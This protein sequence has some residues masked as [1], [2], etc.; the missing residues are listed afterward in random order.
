MAETARENGY[1]GEHRA[2]SHRRLAPPLIHCTPGFRTESVPMFLS[3]NAT[4]PP[5]E[6]R[7]SRFTRK[8]EDEADADAM[9]ADLLAVSPKPEPVTS[10]PAPLPAFHHGRCGL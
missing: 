7:A 9:R 10:S 2:R 8:H 3:D 4:G 5:G 1:D 6:S